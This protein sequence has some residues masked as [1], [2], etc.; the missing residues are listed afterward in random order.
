MGA[1]A[2]QLELASDAER[3]G[4][5]FPVPVEHWNVH[6]GSV[7]STMVLAG[8]DLAVVHSKDYHEVHKFEDTYLL[9]TQGRYAYSSYPASA[10][11]AVTYKAPPRG[12][13]DN[14]DTHTKEVIRMCVD[15]CAPVEPYRLKNVDPPPL[16][17]WSYEEIEQKLGIA[18]RPP[19]NHQSDKYEVY[20]ELG[21]F[22]IAAVQY[23]QKLVSPETL[24]PY[25]VP[26]KTRSVGQPSWYAIP[27]DSD[28]CRVIAAT[29]GG[30]EYLAAPSAQGLIRINES[31]ITEVRAFVAGHVEA[32]D[33]HRLGNVQVGVSLTKTP[34]LADALEALSDDEARAQCVFVSNLVHVCCT[35]TYI[36]DDGAQGSER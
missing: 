23:W 31:Q 28:C 1:R 12:N 35:V 33:R 21:V 7:H 2:S 26:S 30:F 24:A 18:R 6:P 11:M 14:A 29:L 36:G 22:F 16:G 4:R 34:E 5:R 20:E 3:H 27:P 25:R 13:D 15:P 19:L 10:K 17:L 9:F 32:L 8:P